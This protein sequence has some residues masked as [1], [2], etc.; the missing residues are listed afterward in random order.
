MLI[1]LSILFILTQAIYF[2]FKEWA[3]YDE[4]SKVSVGVYEL[5]Y[6]FQM[7]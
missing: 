3:D 7:V 1:K 2:K 4:K 6:E 5:N